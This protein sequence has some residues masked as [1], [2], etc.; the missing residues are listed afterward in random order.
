MPIKV[1]DRQ[2]I[3][4]I[5]AGEVIERPSA[6]VKELVENAIDS[7]AKDISVEIRNG[8]LELIRVTDNGCGIPKAEVRTAFLP[9]ATS[10]ITAI[11]DLQKVY[12]LGFR[13]EALSSIAAV[14]QTEII[15]KCRGDLTAT[16][17]EISGGEEVRMEEI[18]APDGTTVIVRNIFFNTPARR[19][20]MKTPVTEASYI[21]DMMEKC[22]LSHPDVSFRY[23]Q[24]GATKMFTTGSGKLKDLVYALYGK[25]TLRETLELASET[26]YL[27]I[28]GLIGK[29][30]LEKGNRGFE[31]C[32]LN[33]RFIRSKVLEKAVE[34]AYE[35]FMMQHRYPFVLLYLS[36]S[37]EE[38]DV[39]VH[40]S[41][42]EVRFMAE[43]AVYD[44]VFGAVRGLLASQELIRQVR[45]SEEKEEEKKVYPSIEPFETRRSDSY[46]RET[47]KNAEASVA[48]DRKPAYRTEAGQ[49]SAPAPSTPGED[50]IGSGKGSA[51]APST[52]GEDGFGPGKG[53][54]PAASTP[55]G[56]T[57]KEDGAPVREDRE[58]PV[59]QD[60][61]KD[62]FL[63]EEGRK[64]HRL[65]GQLF[66]TYWLIEYD[67]RLFIVDQHAAHEKVLFE[68]KMKQLAERVP[69]SQN[70]SPPV[71]VTL[72]AREEVLLNRFIDA[73]TE[74]GYEISGFG[75]REYVISAVP[76]DL[77]G[78]DMKSLFTE[79]LGDLESSY[80]EKKPD[81]L[82]QKV[83]SMSCKAAVK[84]HDLLSTEEADALIREL[85]TLE[86]PYACPHGRPTIISITRAEMEKKFRRT[87]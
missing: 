56:E 74:L 81:M 68:R 18:G 60:L 82:L 1:L 41:K 84:G 30:S 58:K 37:P 76:D 54:A 75:G 19:K 73:F 25:D 42:R 87:V 17:F 32:F 49:G 36:L 65:I 8:G 53:A 39:N 14:T 79:I 59:Q 4:K 50:A 51:P 71:T 70:I 44:Q 45:L 57:R 3:E 77:F 24:N 10:K 52:P 86:N 64:K 62:R 85:L 38:Y 63:S 31:N 72:T 23:I 16:D 40:P 83:A 67:D 21:A 33:G 2:T 9:H 46:I 48:E 5:A 15:T 80:G 13:G 66:R 78:L 61:F 26:P 34:T 28:H 27:R 35:P 22:A 43:S 20:F 11:E 55:G 47:L 12:S 29:P 69:V 6:V 7:G